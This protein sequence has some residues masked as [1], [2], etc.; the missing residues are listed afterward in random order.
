[1]RQFSEKSK[2]VQHLKLYGVNETSLQEY[3]PISGSSLISEPADKFRLYGHEPR[4]TNQIVD[5][6]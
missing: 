2:D 3:M 6:K 4:N 5:E 1:M